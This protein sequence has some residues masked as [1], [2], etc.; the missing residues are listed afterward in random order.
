[1]AVREEREHVPGHLLHEWIVVTAGDRH[2]RVAEW[3]CAPSRR[4][5]VARRC[6][7]GSIRKLSAARRART[8]D[9]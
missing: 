8:G 3:L 6:L 2:G 4:K 9:L 7:M 1:V 5:T